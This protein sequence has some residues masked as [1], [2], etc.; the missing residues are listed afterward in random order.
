MAKKHTK[1]SRDLMFSSSHWNIPNIMANRS[2]KAIPYAKG[3]MQN[4]KEKGPLL[5]VVETK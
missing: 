2:Y 1:L 5:P 3:L 4:K